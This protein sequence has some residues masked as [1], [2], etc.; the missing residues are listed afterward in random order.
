MAWYGEQTKQRI[1]GKVTDIVREKCALL[2]SEHK[3]DLSTPFPPASRPRQYPHRRTGNLIA[4]VL[5]MVKPA[6]PG[7]EAKGQVY[8]DLS[9]A[10]YVRFLLA[11]GRRGITE[12]FAR[13]RSRL[14]SMSHRARQTGST[15]IAR[16]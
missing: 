14:A 2:Q 13:I 4:A 11:K 5:V 3:K 15:G 10:E 6:G 16:G 7:R 12:T 8:Y 1:R 9:R